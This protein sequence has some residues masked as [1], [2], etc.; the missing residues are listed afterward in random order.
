MPSLQEIRHSLLDLTFWEFEGLL[1]DLGV[2]A[3]VAGPVAAPVQ[4]VH[5]LLDVLQRRGIDPATHLS[6]ALT[7]HGPLL[8]AP[9]RSSPGHVSAKCVL[10][11]GPWSER[12]NPVRIAR[13]R[14]SFVLAPSL[15]AY[16]SQ[17]LLCE[18]QRAF[19]YGYD[20]YDG[21]TMSL[22]AFLAQRDRLTL[23][24]RRA[25]FYD[26]LVSHPSRETLQSLSERGPNASFG[27]LLL[28]RAASP[29]HDSRANPLTLIINVV[30]AD[31]KAIMGV[32]AGC[33]RE[34]AWCWDAAIGTLVTPQQLAGKRTL[35][36]VARDLVASCFGL[37]E[38]TMQHVCVVFHSLIAN[39][40]NHEPDLLGSAM[41]P[42]SSRELLARAC[43]PGLSNL[44]PVDLVPNRVQ[45]F[46]SATRHSFA[47]NSLECVVQS[48]Q[49]TLTEPQPETR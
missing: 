25:R 15:K 4:R 42:V 46:L 7:P 11:T 5:E 21:E 49:S 39:G 37:D 43:P 47:P 1:R 20:L 31:R 41:I 14:R 8:R 26:F 18:H 29:F 40:D 33:V 36:D 12:R 19:D 34:Y 6:A 30:A 10:A 35:Y 2:Q 3:D 22:F 45:R 27:R 13:H 32:R 28:E 16:E 9:A 24:L 38:L 44:E 48:I 23:H 17:I